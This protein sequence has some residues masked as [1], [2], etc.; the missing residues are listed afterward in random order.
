M[1]AKWDIAGAAAEEAVETLGERAGTGKEPQL[2]RTAH[3]PVVLR[4][5][6]KRLSPGELDEFAGEREGRREEP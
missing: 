1:G 2:V 3:W 6:G 5:E 4:D